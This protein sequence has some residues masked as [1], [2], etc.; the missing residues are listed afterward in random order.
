M[1]T[2]CVMVC[3]VAFPVG[4]VIWLMLARGFGVSRELIVILDAIFIS[5][6]YVWLR[7]VRPT[8]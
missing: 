7:F 4:S 1:L 3:L 8:R 5:L 2:R 6:L